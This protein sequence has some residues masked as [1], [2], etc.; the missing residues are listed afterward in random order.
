MAAVTTGGSGA[1]NSTTP[2]APWPG[3]TIP[4]TT[5]TITI[6]NGHTLSIPA[7]YTAEC[8]APATPSTQAIRTEGSAG[9]GILTCDGALI[10]KANVLQGNANWAF[11]AGSSYT[12]RHA[13]T[14][15]THQISD[16]SNQ[17]KRLTFTGTSGSPCTVTSD[18]GVNGSFTSGG[19]LNG[20]MIQATHTDFSNLGTGSVDAMQPRIDSVQAT[21]FINFTDCRFT[22]CGRVHEAANLPANCTVILQRC[23]FITPANVGECFRIGGNGGALGTGTRLV[24][25]CSTQ[26]GWN[27]FGHHFTVTEMVV[28]G[29]ANR[30]SAAFTNPLSMTNCA[31]RTTQSSGTAIPFLVT[32]TQAPAIRDWYL[33]SYGTGNSRGVQFTLSALTADFTIDG[34]LHHQEYSAG[35]GDGDN[36]ILQTGPGSARV[37]TVQNCIGLPNGGGYSNGCFLAPLGNFST[38]TIKANHNT[39]CG[40]AGPE[41]G[42]NVGDAQSATYNSGSALYTEAKSNL[43]YKGTANRSS[44][45]SRYFGA[46]NQQDTATLANVN[47]NWVESPASGSF[48]GGDADQYSFKQTGTN[49]FFTTTPA[50]PITNGDPQLV[51][52]TRTH[53]TWDASLGGAGTGAAA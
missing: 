48:L 25:N 10:V 34:V 51:A 16:A 45:F 6:A 18:G 32:P 50:G 36:I 12:F 46:V 30:I 5:D 39:W 29:D 22:S 44:M 49:A 2:N 42:L 4:G 41:S 27:V 38:L 9:T 52:K 21:I 35:Q 3:G 8:G 28:D 40:D 1:W 53:M 17:H 7:G 23:E 47:N 43:V 33:T 37:V 26:G 14:A 13:S 15:L 31:G 11:S 20:G 24:D 19:F